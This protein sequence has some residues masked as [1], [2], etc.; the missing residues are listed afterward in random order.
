MACSTV[1]SNMI[2]RVTSALQEGGGKAKGTLCPFVK[3]TM[4][5]SDH[6]AC[7]VES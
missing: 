6:L 2:L 1:T 4:F 3:L 5:K 7:V